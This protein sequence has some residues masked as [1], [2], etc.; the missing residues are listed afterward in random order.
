MREWNTEASSA[1]EL[2]WIYCHR[3]DTI[4]SIYIVCQDRGL[5]SRR[6]RVRD[7]DTKYNI[8]WKVE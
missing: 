7:S 2:W 6:V 8:E 4:A 3:Y 5:S 1:C